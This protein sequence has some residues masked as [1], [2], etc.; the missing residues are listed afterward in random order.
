MNSSVLVIGLDGATWK[1]IDPLIKGNKLPFLAKLKKQ[2]LSGISQSTLPPL[3][4]SVWTSFLTGVNPGKH[5]IFGFL[6]YRKENQH[7]FTNADIKFEPITKQVKSYVSFGNLDGLIKI[8]GTQTQKITVDDLIASAKVK[9]DKFKKF[10]AKNPETKL[11]FVLFKEVDVAQHL[12][13]GT[14][15]LADFYQ[16]LDGIV[17]DV[18]SYYQNQTRK[19]KTFIIVSDHGF[20]KAA[21][22]QFSI[23]PWLTKQLAQTHESRQLV[24]NIIHVVNKFLKDAGL[25]MGKVGFVKDRR[26]KFVDNLEKERTSGLAKDFGIRAT[27]EGLYFYNSK[28]SKTL[29][30]NRLTKLKYE[31]KAV[32]EIVKPADKVYKGAFYDQGPDIVF[33]PSQDIHLNI[34]PIETNIFSKYETQIPADHMSDINGIYMMNTQNEKLASLPTKI[35]I[36]DFRPIISDLLGVSKPLGLDGVSPLTNYSLLDQ[37]ILQTKAI[38]LTALNKYKEHLGIAFTGRKDSLVVMHMLRQVCQEN[39]LNMPIILFIDHGQ[40]FAQSYMFLKSIAKKWKL[41]IIWENTEIQRNE[42]LAESK[43]RA[44][45]D[46]VS[47]H[48]LVALVTAIRADEAP[49]RKKET[50]FSDRKTHTRVHPIL[51]FSE[52]D[53]WEYIKRFNLPYNPLYDFGYRSLEERKTTTKVGDYKKPERAG[54]DKQKEKVMQSLRKLGYF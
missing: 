23:Y 49:A 18:Y 7:F 24:W 46:S 30:V 27:F 11:S 40:H 45:E 39:K 12:L 51:K 8:A 47:K 35:S 48:S 14:R 54:R 38:L 20:H 36:V 9:A 6:N 42:T 13:W 29:L 43:I 3:T 50:F 4:P 34:S 37:K 21:K 15:Q 52:Y 41:N 26:N 2:N 44:I 22:V 53:V 31:G 10:L 33:M 5:A 17:D 19:Q 25:D 16:Q 28:I 1:V 32:F